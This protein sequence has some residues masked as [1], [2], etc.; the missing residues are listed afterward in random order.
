MPIRTTKYRRLGRFAIIKGGVDLAT[1]GGSTK[2]LTWPALTSLTAGTNTTPVAATFYTCSIFVPHNMLMTGIGYLIGTVGGTD[3]AIVT[4]HDADGK[5]LANSDLAGTTVGTA[6][7]FQEIPFTAPVQVVGPCWYYLT[8]T[9]NGITARIRTIPASLGIS[10]T[11]FTKS[12]TGT[13]GTV[14]DLTVPT[15]FIADVAPIAYTY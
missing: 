15:G 7:T 8:V 10:V 2:L 5:L 12:A 14:G 4:L 6:A 13:F 3:K 11:A 9:Y 1:A